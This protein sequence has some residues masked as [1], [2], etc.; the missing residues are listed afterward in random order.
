MLT[1]NQ[2]SLIGELNR[3]E[4]KYLNMATDKE[5]IE[6][7][8]LY[9]EFSIIYKKYVQ[10]EIHHI[11]NLLVNQK[12]L[13]T[14]KINPYIAG[15]IAEGVAGVGAGVYSAI[16]TSERNHQI[17]EQRQTSEIAVKQSR[18]VTDSNARELISIANKLD[19]YLNKN[20]EIKNFRQKDTKNYNNKLKIYNEAMEKMKNKKYNEAMTLFKKV[21]NF[22]DAK[23]QLQKCEEEKKANN[24]ATIFTIV[25][26]IILWLII[27]K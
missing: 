17:E 4:K 18:I 13:E 6:L 3:N 21:G 8:K 7:E 16:K 22:L 10:N 1:D 15:G 14:H 24:F 26:I 19:K 25:V 23:K 11:G 2:T 20:I 9:K 5:K 12:S 27:N